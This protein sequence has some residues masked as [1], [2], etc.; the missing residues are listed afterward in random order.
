MPSDEKLL[1]DI[2]AAPVKPDPSFTP[3]DSSTKEY[4]QGVRRRDGERYFDR[5]CPEAY[6]SFDVTH[7]SIS[8]NRAQISRVITWEPQAKGMLLSGPTGRG[9]TRACWQLLKRLYAEQGVECRWYHAMDFFTELHECIKYGRDDARGWIEAVA[10]RNVVF[11]D[12]WGQEVNL[13]ARE[14]WA[15]SWFFR[16][17]DL[18]LER[19]LPLIITTNM[20][21]KDI[22]ERNNNLRG[23]PLI[24]RLLEVCEIVKFQ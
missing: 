15:Q 20:G 7:H 14:D 17:L 22:A 2:M 5:F 13:K 12:D 3:P 24:R 8:P 23:D 4:I 16:F 21:A 11:M 19:R 6:R 10:W 18:R 9:K 1:A